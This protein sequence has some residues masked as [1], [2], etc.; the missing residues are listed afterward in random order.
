M[1]VL[2]LDMNL[3]ISASL[4]VVALSQ[5]YA[6]LGLN[7][8]LK[9]FVL[10]KELRRVANDVLAH[11]GILTKRSALGW[12]GLQDVLR[13][14]LDWEYMAVSEFRLVLGLWDW[15]KGGGEVASTL[16]LICEWERGKMSMKYSY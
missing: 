13:V 2:F 15:G 12:I 11:F 10:A 4:I 16:C 14:L 8:I 7:S 6:P 5:L 3:S 1:T 9:D